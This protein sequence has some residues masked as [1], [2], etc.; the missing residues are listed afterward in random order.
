MTTTRQR[1]LAY[2]KKHQMVSAID[3]SRDLGM[4]QANARHHLAILTMDNRVEVLGLNQAEGRGR[5]QVLYGMSRTAT[6]NNLDRIADK[7]LDLLLVDLPNK[8]RDSRLHS[9]AKK[10]AGECHTIRNYYITRR[11]ALT[12]DHI[13]RM[14]YHAHWEAHAA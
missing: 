9:L 11:L 2:I 8:E 12:V 5:P 13:N 14:N 3:I 4:T 7:L 6:G 1:V 10:L